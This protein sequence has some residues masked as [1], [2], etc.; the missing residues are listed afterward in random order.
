[1]IS[2]IRLDTLA[3]SLIVFLEDVAVLL[4]DAE[5]L[6][7]TLLLLSTL[8]P[9]LVSETAAAAVAPPSSLLPTPLLVSKGKFGI[10]LAYKLLLCLP[11][12][13]SSSIST[14]VLSCATKLLDLNT[15]WLALPG[16][17]V[18]VSNIPLL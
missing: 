16:L 8:C 15:G 10:T 17:S 11:G 5:A 13:I 2:S 9:L 14:L 7:V 3:L 18:T 6:A 4:F 1:M 12:V